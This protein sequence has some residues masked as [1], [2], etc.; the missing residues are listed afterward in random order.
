MTFELTLFFW[1]IAFEI[2]PFTVL[3]CVGLVGIIWVFDRISKRGVG[4]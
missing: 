3:A 1:S 4:Q 2:H